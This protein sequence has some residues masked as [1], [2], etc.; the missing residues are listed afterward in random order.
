MS[1]LFCDQS[2]ISDS[3][4]HITKN[5][6]DS[7][8]FGNALTFNT[9]LSGSHTNF[10]YREHADA[11]L[12]PFQELQQQKRILIGDGINCL[13]KLRTQIFSSADTQDQ[14]A[15]LQTA[16]QLA[17][18]LADYCIADA[19]NRASHL[20]DHSYHFQLQETVSKM[21]LCEPQSRHHIVPTIVADNL[22]KAALDM[23]LRTEEFVG[24]LES[25]D[26]RLNDAETL[27]VIREFTVGTNDLSNE[28]KDSLF[29][30]STKVAGLLSGGLV[31]ALMAKKIAERYGCESGNEMNVI[32]VAVG[33]DANQ[34]VFEL[35][36]T[37]QQVDKLVLVDDVIDSGSSILSALNAAEEVFIGSNI[38]CGLRTSNAKGRISNSRKAHI[39]HLSSWVQDFADLTDEGQLTE[40]KKMLVEA[41]AYATA[42]GVTLQPGWYR[43]SARYFPDAEAL[44]GK[45][46]EESS[47]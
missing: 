21:N 6:T 41:H 22:R 46:P 39:A 19:L 16:K 32:A 23:A 40:A 31:Y 26:R 10:R 4:E 36:G 3:F 33:T 25:P 35:D 45:I 13:R 30:S 5:I 2:I 7:F 15:F 17:N 11:A 27:Q 29:S 44:I 9:L 28:A 12:Q 14:Q 37:D 1:F 42:N 20:A 24:N 8:M 47:C 34:A 43:R 18:E 38:Y